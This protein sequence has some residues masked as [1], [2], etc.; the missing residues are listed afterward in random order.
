MTPTRYRCNR[1]LR[2]LHRMTPQSLL[3]RLVTLFPGFGP[4]WDDPGNCFRE[5]DGTFNFYGVFAELS[6]FL[7]EPEM[8]DDRRAALGELVSGCAEREGDPGNAVCTNFIEC[9]AGTPAGKALRPHLTGAAL[10]YYR[11][12]EA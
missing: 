10:A 3:D 1:T 9:V 12:W 4:F 2:I 11:L 6:S 5:D 7:T 8:A